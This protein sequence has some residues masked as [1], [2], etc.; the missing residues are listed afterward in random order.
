[1]FTV[2]SIGSSLFGHLNQL[3]EV[4]TEREKERKKEN[5]LKERRKERKK[6]RFYHLQRSRA[7]ESKPFKLK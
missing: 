1:M 3:N 4:R 7:F 5:M 2:F 6:E